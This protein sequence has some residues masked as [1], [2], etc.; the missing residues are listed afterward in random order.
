MTATTTQRNTI[1]AGLYSLADLRGFVAFESKEAA[2]ARHV[3]VWLGRVLN[4]TGH[5]AKQ[6][7]YTFSDLIS[8]FVVR[9][10]L[11]EGVRPRNIRAA[12]MYLRERWKLERPFIRS[13]NIQTDGK[14]VWVDGEVI[15]GQ[16]ESADQ[17][18]QQALLEPIRTSLKRVHFDDG[19]AAYWAPMNGIVVDPRVQFG[20]PVVQGTRIP[21]SAVAGVVRNLGKEEAALR[22]GLRAKLLENALAF[23]DQISALN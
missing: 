17:R 14:H 6:P 4:P 10:L 20:E 8:L 15:P 13:A 22:F 18:G 11:R 19:S 23:E 2:D 1:G 7:D 9:Q 16:I 21:T 12:E 5:Q 3:V